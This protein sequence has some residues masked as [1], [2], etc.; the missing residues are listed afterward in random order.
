MAFGWTAATWAMIGAVAGAGVS[1]YNGQ[2]AAAGQK[3]A[4]DM[5]NQANADAK[6][7]ALKQEQAAE[8]SNNKANQKSAD[9]KSILEAAGASGKAGV[10]STMLTG[11]SGVDLEKLQLGKNT[12]LGS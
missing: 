4:L 3:K 5:Q 6:S 2:Q 7:A 10:S 1:L 9:T 11:P 8:E 12:L